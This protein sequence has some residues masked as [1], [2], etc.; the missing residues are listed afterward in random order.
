MDTV[1]DSGIPHEG[2]QLLDPSYTGLLVPGEGDDVGSRVVA[3]PHY[4]K[5]FPAVD[6][7]NGQHRAVL[8]PSDLDDGVRSGAR[9]RWMRRWK[10]WDTERSELHSEG[11]AQVWAWGSIFMDEV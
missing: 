8:T 7:T 4:H 1:G 6:A 3:A 2:R 10:R 9:R 5:V 11:D